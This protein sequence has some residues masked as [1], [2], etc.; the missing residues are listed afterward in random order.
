META[1]AIA[2]AVSEWSKFLC[3]PAGQELVKS[4]LASRAAFA[5]GWNR[6]TGDIATGFKALTAARGK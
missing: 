1:K 6:L 5:A 3:S 4:D 2:M